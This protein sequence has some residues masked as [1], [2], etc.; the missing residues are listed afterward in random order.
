MV[1]LVQGLYILSK[2]Y[3]KRSERSTSLC[4]RRYQGG[5][6][7][8]LRLRTGDWVIYIYNSMVR[9]AMTT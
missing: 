3:Q 4:R 5:F 6:E 2:T 9:S 7:I 1:R 8:D